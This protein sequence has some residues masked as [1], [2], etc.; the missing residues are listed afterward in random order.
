MNNQI[1]FLIFLEVGSLRLGVLICL[2]KCLLLWV[3][4]VFQERR[5]LDM[6]SHFLAQK[7]LVLFSKIFEMCNK[8]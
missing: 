7:I 2:K 6:S 3:V 5:H 1:S 4:V 8:I